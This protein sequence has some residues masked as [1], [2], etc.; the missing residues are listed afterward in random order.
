MVCGLLPPLSLIDTPALRIPIT[1]G[2]NVTLMVQDFL[3]GNE[4]PQVGVSAKSPGSA[5]VSVIEEMETVPTELSL[6]TVNTAG[7]LVV[8]TVCGPKRKLVGDNAMAVPDPCS[9]T[10]C[11]EP[12]ALSAIDRFAVRVL[13]DCGAKVT[14][15]VQVLLPARLDPQVLVC[16][17][18]PGFAPVKVIGEMDMALGAVLER[19]T[20]CGVLPVPRTWAPNVMLLGETEKGEL[21]RTETSWLGAVG[22]P[23]MVTTRSGL[24]SPFRSPVWM[25]VG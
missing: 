4:V 14:L 15:M 21:S 23:P 3:G 19:V 8:P 7:L 6:V 1:V 12:A 17:K 10:V 25:P 22:N 18:S 13:I 11:G 24:P 9:A 16:V 5:P 20:G 2:L